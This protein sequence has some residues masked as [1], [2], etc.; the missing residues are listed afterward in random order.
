MTDHT[1]AVTRKFGRFFPPQRTAPQGASIR[2]GEHVMCVRTVAN[3]IVD[4]EF[5]ERRAFGEDLAFLPA[6]DVL[7]WG[8][9]PK[10]WVTRFPQ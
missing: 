10:I 5:G 6:L 4:I 1:E 2:V 9:S 3:Q 7:Q 8:Q